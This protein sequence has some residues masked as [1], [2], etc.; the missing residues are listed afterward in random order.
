MLRNRFQFSLKAYKQR[1]KRKPMNKVN[2]IIIAVA[3]I[4][5]ILTCI[6]ILLRKPSNPNID[7]IREWEKAKQEAVEQKEP[8]K[9]HTDDGW[10]TN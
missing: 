1:P 3:G 4:L 9:P 8:A 2:Q 6:I 10:F 5:V 7:L